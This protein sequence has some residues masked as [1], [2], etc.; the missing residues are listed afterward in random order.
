MAVASVSVFLGIQHF[1]VCTNKSMDINA[2]IDIGMVLVCKVFVSNSLVNSTNSRRGAEVAPKLPQQV[3]EK[4][5][6][7]PAG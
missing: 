2:A 6:V 5:N 3:V 4:F 1:Q 7:L